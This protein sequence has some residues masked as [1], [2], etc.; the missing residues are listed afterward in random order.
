M[1]TSKNGI[2]II[3][4]YEGCKL[5]TYKCPAGIPTIGYGH[6]GMDVS[7]GMRITDGQAERLLAKDCGKTEHFINALVDVQLNQNQFDAL[8]SF[9]FNVGVGALEDSTLLKKLNSKD[10]NG[11]KLEFLRWNKAAGKVLHGLTA[12][13]IEESELFGAT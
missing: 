11:A 5:E 7:I 4:K 8:V 12:R 9:T 1:M 13:R 10:Y 2:C 3:K 6:T